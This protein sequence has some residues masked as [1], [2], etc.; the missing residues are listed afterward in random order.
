MF[1]DN[2]DVVITIADIEYGIRGD[3]YC[4]PIAR[5]I[6]RLVPPCSIDVAPS[7]SGDG[8]VFIK[9]STIPY[10]YPLPADI[11]KAILEYDNTGFFPQ[12]KRVFTLEK[13]K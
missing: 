13:M 10:V 8:N 12:E 11:N 2:I 9:N 3:P 7:I 4:C 5:A 6:S 1:P